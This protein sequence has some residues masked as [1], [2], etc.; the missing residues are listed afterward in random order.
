MRRPY[1]A[2][3]SWEGEDVER[4]E[5]L[6]GQDIPVLDHGF[7]RLVDRMGGDHAIVQ[8]TRPKY[9]DVIQKALAVGYRVDAE[10]G[11]ILGISGKSLAIRRHGTQKYPTVTLVYERSPHR[12][13]SV[14]AHKV[15][16]YA[17]WGDRSY[18]PGV[19]VRHKDGNRE[20]IRADNLALGTASMNELDK[21]P[22]VRRRTAKI[23]RAAQG[24]R[25]INAVLSDDQVRYIR[26]I[27]AM[28]LNKN[29]RVRRGIVKSLSH[30]FNVSK[31]AISAAAKGTTY[32]RVA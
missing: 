3:Y 23:A 26:G 6:L 1:R 9:I 20:N 19:Q 4:V 16:A 32:G 12:F 31:S 10:K 14:P 30:Q 22:E 28:N 8:L 24:P 25:P 27:C 18:A 7:V 5:D 21:A 13:A 29:G 2:M 17:I 15:M 11:L